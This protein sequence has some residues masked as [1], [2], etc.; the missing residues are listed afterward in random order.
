MIFHRSKQKF[1]KDLFFSAILF[2]GGIE[3]EKF[4]ADFKTAEIVIQIVWFFAK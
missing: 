4:H 3:N 1:S 2:Y